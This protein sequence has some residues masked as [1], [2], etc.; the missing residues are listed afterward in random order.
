MKILLMNSARTW[1]GTEKW[2]RMTAESLAADHDVYLAYG[3]EIVGNR[4]TVTRYRLPCLSHIDLYTL[5]RLV[6]IIR[7]EK[8]GVIIPTKRKDYLLAGLAA[9][10]CGITN[11]LRLGIERRLRMPIMHRLVYH[12]LADGIIV[13]AEKIKKSLL[14]SPF[15]KAEDIRVIY[16]GVDTAAI[17]RLREPPFRKNATFLVATAGV[18]TNRKGHDFL[19]RGFAGFLESVPQ[20]DACLVIMGEGPKETELRALAASLGIDDRILFTGFVDNPFPYM[21]SSDVFA[22][23]SINEGISNALLESMYLGNVP[24][25]TAAGGT[26]ELL[27]NGENGFLVEYGDTKA[28]SGILE[29]LYFDPELRNRIS[30]AAGRTVRENFTLA[31]MQRAITGFCLET[32]ERRTGK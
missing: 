19:I 18:L 8:I 27:R 29:R 4:F 23:T 5:F 31:S 11:I 25:S 16:N 24:V 28:L 32:Q 13:N 17:D 20:A 14:A 1:G 7:R 2:T 3:R 22:M 21:A 9:R 6:R 30:V 10:I 26:A 12:T 15:M